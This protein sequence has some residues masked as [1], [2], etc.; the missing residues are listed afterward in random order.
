MPPSRGDNISLDSGTIKTDKVSMRDLEFWL[1]FTKPHLINGVKFAHSFKTLVNLPILQIG[2]IL[3]V[4]IK[5][6]RKNRRVNGERLSNCSLKVKVD[7]WQRIM[8]NFIKEEDK[9]RML[10]DISYFIC[11]SMIVKL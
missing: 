4:V 8:R 9:Q 10:V 7:S 3:G 11:M 1:P 6:F 2:Y 5:I